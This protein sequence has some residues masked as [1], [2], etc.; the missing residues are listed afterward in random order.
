MSTNDSPQIQACF[1][2]TCRVLA[3]IAVAALGTLAAIL[4]TG[5]KQLEGVPINAGISYSGFGASYSSKR[6]I[7]VGADIDQFL[8]ERNRVDQNSGK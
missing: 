3:V 7:T 2:V 4:F 1:R 5:C 8:R 6:G